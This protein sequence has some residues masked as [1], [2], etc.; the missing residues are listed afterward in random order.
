MKYLCTILFIIFPIT[1]S[2]F[3]WL[4]Y[5]RRRPEDRAEGVK[6]MVSHWE[7]YGCK[8]KGDE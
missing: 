3:I 5:R 2:V 7:Q 4:K 8:E 1:I 6:A